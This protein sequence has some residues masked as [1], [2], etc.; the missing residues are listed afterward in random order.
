MAKVS[1]YDFRSIPK[2]IID[3]TDDLKNILN[4]GK[5][6]LPVLSSPPNWIPGDG[7]TV[8]VDDDPDTFLYFALN[9]TWNAID[10]GAVNIEGWITFSGTGTL[11]TYD[12]F[13]VTGITRVNSAYLIS[14]DIDFRNTNYV[15]MGGVREFVGNNG[16]LFSLTSTDSNPTVGTVEM[17]A[18]NADEITWG[19]DREPHL[20]TAM[21]IGLQ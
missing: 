20:A 7:E 17:S 14:W 4:N 3:F 21:A 16:T 19:I 9:G 2:E 5:Y 11:T 8:L 10:V 18:R 12:S 13:N 15:C 6:Q 1:D